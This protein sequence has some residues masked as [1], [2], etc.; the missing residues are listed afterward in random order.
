LQ[1]W[2]WKWA[3]QKIG[4][5]FRSSPPGF[6]VI[7]QEANTPYNSL[8]A[9]DGC[10]FMEHGQYSNTIES[11]VTTQL[12]EGAANGKPWHFHAMPYGAR[13]IWGVTAAISRNLYERLYS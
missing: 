11:V 9:D 6:P 12:Q 5:P 8:R 3:D 2:A 7:Q 1:D 10:P 4:S 13:N